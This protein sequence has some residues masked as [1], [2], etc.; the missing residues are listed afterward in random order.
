[1]TLFIWSMKNLKECI[2]KRLKN[3]YDLICFITGARG[4]GKSTFV[5]KLLS[6]LEIENGFNP[7]RDIVYSR[8]DTLKSLASKKNSIIWNDELVM[9]AYNRDFWDETQKTLL[10]ALNCYR[11]QCN[12][13]IGCVPN[14]MD[15]D[16]QLQRLCKLRIHIVKRGIGLIFIK[17][18]NLFSNDPWQI[19]ASQA[20]EKKWSE[21]G[22]KKP[23]Y[24][25]ISTIVGIIRF[26]D[27]T[28]NQ[29]D[30]YEKIKEERRAKVFGSFKD[31]TL[32]KDPEKLF[33]DNMLKQIK[34]RGITPQ[35]FHTL[36]QVSSKNP[37]TVRK[38]INKML[39]EAGDTKRCFDYVLGK[40]NSEKRDKLGYKI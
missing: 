14:F 25:Q 34:G 40:N 12:L 38:N 33:Y 5:Y 2:E 17:K 29:R 8:D 1:M 26:G 18:D 27:I 32:M 20:I 19:K 22:N 36:C 4:D 13:F 7:S 10:K 23:K 35:I 3:K 30:I 21:E 11:D 9:S 37:T 24:A 16:V 31:E 6:S 28:P 39:F 15:L